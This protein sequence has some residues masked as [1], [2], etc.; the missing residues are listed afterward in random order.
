LVAPKNTM[1]FDAHRDP[2]WGLKAKSIPV[3]T[4]LGR[5][6]PL[7]TLRIDTH[8]LCPHYWDFSGSLQW[9]TKAILVGRYIFSDLQAWD[10]CVGLPARQGTK[11]GFPCI[12]VKACPHPYNRHSCNEYGK[13]GS[14]VQA[15][16]GQKCVC[17]SVCKSPIVALQY[18]TC[19]PTQL[20]QI[21]KICNYVLTVYLPVTY[22]GPNNPLYSRSDQ[23][24]SPCFW[25]LALVTDLPATIKGDAT[26]LYPTVLNMR[27]SDKKNVRA[28]ANELR[29]TAAKCGVA[30][31]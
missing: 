19:N 22:G 29:V 27:H 21:K 24:W 20:R 30:F 5:P 17:G 6:D 31:Y 13:S 14:C 9:K 10:E 23:K 28:T 7:R 15:I 11:H 25:R 8:P 16:K 1:Y 18:H 4:V 2:H 3:I 26:V 12:V